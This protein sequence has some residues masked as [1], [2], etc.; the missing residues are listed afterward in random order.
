MSSQNKIWLFVTDL[1]AKFLFSV[2]NATLSTG[3]FY[4]FVST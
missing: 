3:K 1:L 4:N 2:Y